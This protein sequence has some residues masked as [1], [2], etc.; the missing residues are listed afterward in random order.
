LPSAEKALFDQINFHLP[1]VTAAKDSIL[2]YFLNFKNNTVIPNVVN[3]MNDF[4]T[5]SPTSN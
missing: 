2:C 4:K 3:G 1:K 5:K